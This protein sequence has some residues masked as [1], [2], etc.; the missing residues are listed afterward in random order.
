MIPQHAFDRQS[1]T[2]RLMALLA[3]PRTLQT[4]ALCAGRMGMRTA[5]DN[6][7]NLVVDVIG[8]GRNGDPQSRLLREAAR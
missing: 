8:D 7:A 4:T 3:N 6:L 5:A 2:T 1:L